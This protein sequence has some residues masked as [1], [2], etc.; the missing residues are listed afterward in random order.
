MLSRR[1]NKGEA[2]VYESVR[3]VEER[4]VLRRAG[5]VEGGV[6]FVPSTAATPLKNSQP[7]TGAALARALILYMK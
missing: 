2:I 3:V 6:L 4:V 7:G 5:K 1:D